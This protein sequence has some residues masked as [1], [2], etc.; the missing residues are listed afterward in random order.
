MDRPEVPPEKRPSVISAQ[1][2]PRPLDFRYEVGYSI[3]CMPGPPRGP[4]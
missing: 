3:S 1:T 2:L 4:S